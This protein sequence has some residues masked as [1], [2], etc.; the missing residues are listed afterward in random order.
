M[1]DMIKLLDK[2]LKYENHE[3]IDSESHIWVKSRQKVLPCP[4]CGEKS[5]KVHSSYRRTIQDLPISGKKVYLKI[6]CRKMFCRTAACSRKT[7]AEKFE[8]VFA[9]GKKSLRLE[10]EIINIAMHS[11]STEASRMLNRSTV[12]ISSGTV[13]NLLKK[14]ES[15]E[16]GES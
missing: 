5:K 4:Y 3:I 8:F 16:S 10:K 2:T 13:R 15:A 6:L 14:M 1:K 7:F 9:K 11:S 12:K